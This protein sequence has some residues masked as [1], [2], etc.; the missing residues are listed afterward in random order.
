MEFVAALFIAAFKYILGVERLRERVSL[1]KGFGLVG[2]VITARGDI[3][4][5]VRALPAAAKLAFHLR[6]FICFLTFSRSRICPLPRIYR[7]K[8]LGATSSSAQS[9]SSTNV[10][11]GGNSHLGV[12]A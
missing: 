11:Q 5:T 9:G 2:V 12:D 6:L 3:L 10:T 1:R 8:T 7:D 4:A